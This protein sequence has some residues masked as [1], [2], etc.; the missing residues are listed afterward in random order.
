MFIRQ[1]SYLVALAKEKHFGRAAEK[2][3]VTQSTLSAG[4]QALERE[5]DMRLVIRQP[6]FL[7]LT[8]EGERV[9]DWAQQI[10]AD[11]DNLKLDVEGL[12]GGLK[13]T[14]RLGVIPAAM[15]TVAM[16]TRPF[17]EQYAKVNVEVRSLTSAAIQAA[18]DD[19]TLDAG[20]TYLDNE[21]PTQVRS[22]RLYL[23]HYLFVTHKN[24]ALG[25]CSEVR[26]KEAVGERLCLLTEDMQN[27]RIM[28][29]L[30]RALGLPLNPS[31]T[32]NSFLAVCSHVA[33]GAWSS[34]IPNAF[35]LIFSG[36]QDI[37]MR[38][39]VEPRHEQAIGLVWTDRDPVPPLAAAFTR[40]AAL[41]DLDQRMRELSSLNQC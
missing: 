35:S 15:P 26:W 28:N 30:T 2:C 19:F 21:P 8:P 32:T 6:R 16:L 40:T 14:L 31:V 20:I 41:L 33:S 18:L 22:R 38:P 1:M 4:L 10:L 36:C 39:L 37:V 27:R 3:C 11:Y 13:G 25:Q 5:L 29:N 17:Q 34:I 7:G 12:R 23:E 9:V 24:N